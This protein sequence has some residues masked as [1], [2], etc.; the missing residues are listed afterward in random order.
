MT[1]CR[2]PWTFLMVN[3]WTRKMRISVAYCSRIHYRRRGRAPGLNS[4][5]GSYASTCIRFV[6]EGNVG[7]I[8]LTQRPRFNQSVNPPYT[9][10]G[11]IMPSSTAVRKYVTPV[12][13][14]ALKGALASEI[15]R[16]RESGVQIPH[17]ACYCIRRSFYSYA[18]LCRHRHFA[19]CRR[20]LLE[21]VL[22]SA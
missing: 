20:C 17:R 13:P 21:E 9:R 14:P 2:I 15:P 3:L 11:F 5:T 19:I 18:V 6:I 7:I 12:T 22:P 8:D 16:T 10:L 1:H 4:G